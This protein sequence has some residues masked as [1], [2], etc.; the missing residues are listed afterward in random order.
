MPPV[1]NENFDPALGEYV[2]AVD[3]KTGKWLEG[4]LTSRGISNGK[5]WYRLFEYPAFTFDS[6]E[7]AQ[8]APADES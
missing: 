2:R 5:P 3:S 8:E 4:I 1:E 6:I 7:E